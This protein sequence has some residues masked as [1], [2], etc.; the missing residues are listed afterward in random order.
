MPRQVRL[1]NHLSVAELEQR[2]RQ[3]AQAVERS[4]LQIVW[5]L[6]QG[7][8]AQHVAQVT[9][10]CPA[11][12]GQIARRY[13]QGGPDALGDRRRDNPGGRW[14]LSEEQ[15]VAL[16]RALE[17]APQ[18]GG[19]W[20]STKVAA[21]MSRETGQEVPPQRG[22]DYLRLLGYTPQVPRPRH[23]K[24]DPDAQDTFKKNAA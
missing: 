3:S 5:L 23:R 13:N 20:N 1:E 19:L 22:W 24:A 2:Y 4:H 7:Q 10:Y 11:W 18:D 8:Q 16:A 6:A 14:L 21:W 15:R 12:V 17:Q 9:G